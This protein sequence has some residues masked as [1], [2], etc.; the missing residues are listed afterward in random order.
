MRRKLTLVLAL[1]AL[2]G[3]TSLLSACNTAQGF[4]QDMQAGGRAV[5]NSADRNR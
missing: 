3:G 5:E 2:A 4:G 1:A